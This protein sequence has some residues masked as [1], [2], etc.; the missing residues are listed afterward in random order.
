MLIIVYTTTA[1]NIDNNKNVT[2][3]IYKTALGL[4]GCILEP[5]SRDM[6]VLQLGIFICVCLSLCV[7]KFLLQSV[8]NFFRYFTNKQLLHSLLS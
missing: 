5:S 6:N 8:H 3:F 4:L 7:Y 2:I 1:N